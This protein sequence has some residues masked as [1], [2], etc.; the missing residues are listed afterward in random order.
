MSLCGGGQNSH[1]LVAAPTHSGPS[2]GTWGTAVALKWPPDP[3][4]A[5]PRLCPLVRCCLV[6]T[7]LPMSPAAHT[8]LPSRPS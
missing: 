8:A 4:L 7:D 5:G 2:P 1:Y 6:I 3:W